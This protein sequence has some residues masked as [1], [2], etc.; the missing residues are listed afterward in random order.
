VVFVGGTVVVPVHIAVVT[1]LEAVTLTEVGTNV[2]S[3]VAQSLSSTAQV[4]VIAA[5]PGV[6]V[7]VGV[8]VCASAPAEP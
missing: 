8:G 7:G 5:S 1:V 4:P 2:V 6:G 3:A